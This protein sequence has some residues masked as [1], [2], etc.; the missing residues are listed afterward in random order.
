MLGRTPVLVVCGTRPE[1]IKLAPVIRALRERGRQVLFV[2]TGQ[3]PDLAPS[4]LREA[5]LAP[6]MDLAVHQPGNSPAQL[7]AGMLNLLP[8]AMMAWR[9]ALVLVQGDTVSAMAGAL[10]A[11]YARIPVGHVE[12]GLRTHM[13]DEPFPEEMHRSLIAPLAALHFTPTMQASRELERE[14]IDPANIHLTGNT[15]IDALLAAVRRLDADPGLAENIARRFP[16]LG[17]K[18]RPTLLAT[19]HRRENIGLR[20]ESIAAGLGRLAGFCEADIVLPLH[21]NPAVAGPLRARLGGLD[22]VHLIPPVDH[23][24]MVWLMRQCQ[25]LLTDSGGLQ[26]EAPALGLRTLVLRTFTERPEAVAAGASELVPLTADG[27]VQATRAALARPPLEPVFPF[28]DGTA[29]IRIAEVIDRWLRPP[30]VR[31]SG[32][33]LDAPPPFAASGAGIAQ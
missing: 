5:G 13:R 32:R 1:T 28:G 31:R 24:T 4:L 16:F 7:L 15:A 17:R 23:L 3:H 33:R 6:D 30:R 8:P 25:L 19:V 14:G 9:P 26:E 22:G 21:P 2:V 18:S 11:S 20:L 27:I 10:A 29:A 12:A